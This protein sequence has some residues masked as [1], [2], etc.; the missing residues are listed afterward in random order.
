MEICTKKLFTYYY[1]NVWCGAGANEKKCCGVRCGAEIFF[2]RIVVCGAV[3]NKIFLK[4]VLH[5]QKAI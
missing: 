2:K 1:I 4:N 3:R 5:Y